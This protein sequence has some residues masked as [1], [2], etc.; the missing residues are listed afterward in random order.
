M[1]VDI[2]GSIRI[3]KKAINYVK[4][5][6]EDGE[7]VYEEGATFFNFERFFKIPDDLLNV[8]DGKV[9]TALIHG[10]AALNPESE[11]SW[12]P[13]FPKFENIEMFNHWFDNAFGSK[14]RKPKESLDSMCYV[15][16]DLLT[17]PDKLIKR[18]ECFF[19][20]GGVE[21][22]EEEMMAIFSKIPSLMEKYGCVIDTDYN[23]FLGIDKLECYFR[24]TNGIGYLDFD[25]FNSFPCEIADMLSK[26]FPEEE[27]GV[28]YHVCGCDYDEAVLLVFKAGK[29]M[30]DEHHVWFVDDDEDIIKESHP[31]QNPTSL[32]MENFFPKIERPEKTPEEIEKDKIAFEESIRIREGKKWFNENKDSLLRNSDGTYVITEDMPEGAKIKAMEKNK[33]IISKLNEPTYEEIVKELGRDSLTIREIVKVQTWLSHHKCLK[34][35]NYEIVITSDMP[36]L[37]KAHILFDRKRSDERNKKRN[38]I[39]KRFNNN[40]DD[41]E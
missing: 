17:Q 21:I 4:Q 31:E 36:I 3:P 12:G 26:L 34:D 38:K 2:D 29:C 6:V 19:A 41:F 8:N 1:S 18:D 33:I 39:L 27:I 25:L 10:V 7:D 20:C 23:S 13:D 14:R 11:F 40:S 35:D 16:L 22:T 30:F 28:Y 32:T 5:F 24:V 9:R 15:N 37:V